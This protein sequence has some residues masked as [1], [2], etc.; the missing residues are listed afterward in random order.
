MGRRPAG[1][2]EA[3][4]LLMGATL[5]LCLLG[6]VMVYSASS[7]AD[8]VKQGDAGFHFKRQAMWIL[9]GLLL[10][11]LA[12]R[13]DYRR[14][15]AWSLGLALAADAALVAVLIFGVERNGAKSWVIVGG[16]S[17]QPAEFAK[18]LVLI[19]VAAL[20]AGSGRA[21]DFT[22]LGLRLCAIVLPAA[23]LV[24]GQP[25][26]GMTLSILIAVY[27]AM[28]LGGVRARIMAPLAAIGGAFTAVFIAVDPERV[29]R[30]TAFLHPDADP[31][32]AGY[33]IRQALYA[34]GSGGL[35]GVGLGFSRQ[36][37][38]YLPEAHNDFIFAI[39]GEELGL[40]GT[41]AVVAAFAVVA[42]AGFRIALG[43]TDRFGRLLASSLTAAIVLQALMNMA[44]VTGLM[45]VTGITLPFV[46]SGGS[47]M[48]MSLVCVGLIL[49]VSQRG[50]VVRPVRGR[51]AIETEEH[52][53]AR[54][55]QRRRDRRAHLPG[56]VGRRGDPGRSA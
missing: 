40:L 13:A 7:V 8:I 12:G 47:S 46:S 38:F 35:R 11:F 45:P 24:M 41:L 10:V 6:V 49:S 21:K 37:F 36:K 9:A 28:L 33:Q 17:L 18:P 31:L 43:A 48:L 42:Y 30:F 19:A 52:A 54:S 5:F 44:A 50:A 16:Q 26:F 56:A 2:H 55:D 3:R 14:L 29:E 53:I 34:F 23:M 32:G 27:A 25:D 20:L 51:R 1:G 39:I 22:P 15:R 4:Y